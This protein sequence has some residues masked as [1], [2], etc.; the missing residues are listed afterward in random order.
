MN[1]R[2]IKGGLKSNQEYVCLSCRLQSRLS[3]PR[4]NV[5]YQHTSTPSTDLTP[6]PSDG[7]TSQVPQLPYEQ[8]K[9]EI[10]PSKD[11]Q[12]ATG[13]LP[14]REARELRDA[15][16][17]KFLEKRRLEGLSLPVQTPA[18]DVSNVETK[19]V[20]DAVENEAGTPHVK[21]SKGKAVA[22]RKA[23]LKL[24]RKAKG[25][26]KEEAKKSVAK[27]HEA[28]TAE[29]LETEISPRKR[30][31]RKAKEE[32]KPEKEKK[33]TAAL[34]TKVSKPREPVRKASTTRK[35][36]RSRLEE[37]LKSNITELEKAL[38][39][40]NK[41]ERKLTVESVLSKIS[42]MT[43]VYIIQSPTEPDI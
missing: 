30:K 26:A 19:A 12:D 39:L 36:K 24:K 28:P 34:S 42:K 37:I 20:K 5:R 10:Q 40:R 21:E 27:A 13:Q 6:S 31:A 18:K 38:E 23:A 22:E 41:E 32:E 11:L 16:Q 2:S 8:M 3:Q 15:L 35:S 25:K 4:R 1:L 43:K 9:R 29:K 17:Q 14:S 33:S 7:I